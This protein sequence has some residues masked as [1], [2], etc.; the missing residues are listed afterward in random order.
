M[1]LREFENRFPDKNILG[2]V[3][4]LK[5]LGYSTKALKF[6]SGGQ[7]WLIDESTYPSG[8]IIIEDM[9]LDDLLN[10]EVIKWVNRPSPLMEGDKVMF[11]DGHTEIVTKVKEG[12]GSPYP[13]VTDKSQHKWSEITVVIKKE[14]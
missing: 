8:K 4:D 13:I 12:S 14:A 2:A 1:K 11:T 5:D 7:V 6:Y 10:T 3:L 9:L